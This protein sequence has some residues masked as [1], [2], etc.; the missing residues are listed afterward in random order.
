MLS[1]LHTQSLLEF[2]EYL[3]QPINL[4]IFVD[5]IDHSGI[6]LKSMQN[7]LEPPSSICELLFILVTLWV[8]VEI[9]IL[10]GTN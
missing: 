2:P 7:L 3:S 6:M 10:L 5:H 4:M 1:G 8:S 9:N